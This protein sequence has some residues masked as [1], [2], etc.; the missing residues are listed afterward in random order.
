[1]HENASKPPK[2]ARARPEPD[3]AIPEE[4]RRRLAPWIDVSDVGAAG[5]WIWFETMLPF[6][7]RP[8]NAPAD[9]PPSPDLPPGRMK[10]LARDLADCASD[11]ARLNMLCARYF[12][13]GR[14]LTRR[15]KALEATLRTY[16]SADGTAETPPDPEAERA[17]ERYLPPRRGT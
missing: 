11:R 2:P 13:D 3:L 12:E 9:L 5:F 14:L 10:E 15:V 7:P 4:L 6:L 17:T 16:R 1:V 8:K